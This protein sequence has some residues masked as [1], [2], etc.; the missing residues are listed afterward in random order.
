M[1]REMAITK[2]M[3]QYLT[4]VHSIAGTLKS[5]PQLHKA[6]S[7]FRTILNGIN[8]PTEKLAEVAEYEL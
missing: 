8:T 7:S 6:G 3:K 4:F 1:Y 5:N 2:E